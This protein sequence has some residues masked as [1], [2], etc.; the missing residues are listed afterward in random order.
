[1]NPDAEP[2]TH[3][4]TEHSAPVLVGPAGVALGLGV[5]EILAGL[6][7][8]WRSPIVSVGDRFIDLTPRWLKDFAISAFGTND[9]IAL[10]LGM[11]VT[12]AA[13]S[14]VVG[15]LVRRRF[16]GLAVAIVGAF[17]LVGS[18]A[19]L[20]ARASAN[21]AAALPIVVASIIAI[22]TIV[23]FDRAA[24]R[25]VSTGVDIDQAGPHPSNSGRRSMLAS[26][27]G[28]AV[29]G[30]AMMVGGRRLRSRFSV[31]D[32]I[33]TT[34]L[35][36]T[37]NQ[38][39]AAAA[40]AV[41]PADSA[42]AAAP[43]TPDAMATVEEMLS[44]V[45]DIEGLS[46][47]FTPNAD[48]YRIDTALEVPQLSTADWELEITGMVENE[49]RLSWDDL[50]AR[51]IVEEDITLSCVSNE[52]GGSLLGT[53]RWLG[54]RLDDLLAEAG[55][56]PAADQI[57]GWSVDGFSAGFPLD[58][59]DG[60]PAM[61]AIG[62]N[63]A[64]LPAVHGYPARIIVPGIYGYVSATKWLTRIEI[65]TF[66]AF[67]AYWVERD[68]SPGGV[69]KTQSRIDT[70]R[71]L[72]TLPTGE[73]VIAGVAWAQTRGIE[74]VEVQVDDGPW[75][76]ATLV[77]PGRSAVAPADAPLNDKIWRQWFLPWEATEG[78]HTLT[79]RATDSTGEVQPAERTTPFPSGATGRH[80]TVVQVRDA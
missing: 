46:P 17:G 41:V 77:D 47:L 67:D 38:P 16:L 4:T 52:I 57:V 18:W 32:E 53:A 26:L 40:T 79:V 11:A 44:T 49:L 10:L 70:P 55:V 34:Q 9:K 24:R 42:A 39:S 71:A 75:E 66:D 22:A 5:G 8:A 74:K 37:T 58:A 69:I 76:T 36:T 80:Q 43:I 68:W 25:R 45:P 12:I 50:L 14:F 72:A 1:M 6:V 65:T 51:P 54:I 31:A 63:G 35:P 19:V 73:N 61:I 28:A 29:A 27:S 78:R 59:L 48:F 21:L 64:P 30:L 2:A 3:P 33:Q 7:E 56:D 23:T 62:M 15:G 60:R 20:T 13:L